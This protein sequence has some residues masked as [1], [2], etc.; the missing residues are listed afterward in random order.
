MKKQKDFKRRDKISV[1]N[2]NRV[3]YIEYVHEGSNLTFCSMLE[4]DVESVSKLKGFSE[5]EKK[6]LRKK[7]QVRHSEEYNFIVEENFQKDHKGQKKI[8][9][10]ATLNLKE[11]FNIAIYM[12]TKP[13]DPLYEIEKQNLIKRIGMIVFDFF[14]ETNAGKTGSMYL[15][16]HTA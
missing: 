7:L 12:A 15:Y 14:A 13:G 4:D 3:G 11:E 10:T 2:E 9:A 6:Y 16:R 1:E 5:R 8:I